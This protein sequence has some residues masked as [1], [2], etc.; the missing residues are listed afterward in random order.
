[1]PKNEVTRAVR[2]L[3][4]RLGDTQQSFAHRMGVAISTVV[5]YELSRPPHGKVLG[6]L[7]KM[8]VDNGCFD[9]AAVFRNAFFKE[10]DLDAETPLRLAPF[11]Y[12]RLV[13]QTGHEEELVQALLWELGHSAD[14]AE[15]V[16][17][18]LLRA[19]QEK[20]KVQD[21]LKQAS[22]R[23]CLV[24]CESEPST[25][26]IANKLSIPVAEVQTWTAL[27][28]TF[29]T[30]LAELRSF[31]QSM[32]VGQSDTLLAD[33]FKVSLSTITAVR[34][35]FSEL[36]VPDLLRTPRSA[37]IQTKTKKPT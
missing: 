8:A 9:E 37:V 16:E 17:R 13:P 25:E 1:M 6:Q 24:A 14:G 29:E 2:S 28:D 19:S 12:F 5:R 30:D 22:E 3:R 15:S 26:S 34:R 35:V 33:R 11:E 18:C 20:A 31:L 27:W 23:Y 36:G 4:N 32:G 7:E 21:A 10:F